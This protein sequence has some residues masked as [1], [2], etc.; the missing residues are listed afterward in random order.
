MSEVYFVR[1]GQ[2]SFGAANYDK[3]SPLGHQQSEWLGQYFHERE[4]QFDRVL[5]GDLVRHRETLD[6]ILKGMSLTGSNPP[7]TQIC[8]ELNEFAFGQ[9][10]QAYLTAFPGESV[11]ENPSPEVF[12][13]YLRKAMQL[14]ARNELD[15]PESWHSFEG[16]VL[17]ILQL[18]QHQCRGERVLVV[19]SGGAIAMALVK[20]LKAPK[21]TVVE[22][23]LQTRNTAVSHCY[24]N[25]RSMRLTSFNHVPHLDISGRLDCITYS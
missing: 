6:G 14:W 4:V 8:P 23:N 17:E 18:L 11:P 16:R 15:G 20:I 25:E 13:K 10:L 21:E 3:L 9:L 19:S 7:L 1:H 5:L 22:L 24:F 2:A 12:F